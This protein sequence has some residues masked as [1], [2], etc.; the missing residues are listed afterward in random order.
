MDNAK[1]SLSFLK[2]ASSFFEADLCLAKIKVEEK[3]KTIAFDEKN[4]SLTVMSAD[5]VLYFFKIPSETTR[6]VG[7]AEI[8]TF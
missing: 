1:S 3:N 2:F 8:R 7:E 5:R 6:Y 4:N